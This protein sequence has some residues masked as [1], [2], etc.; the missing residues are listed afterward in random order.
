M[1]SIAAL[2]LGDAVNAAERNADQTTG[3][4]SSRILV[5]CTY[6]KARHRH[7]QL[8]LARDPAIVRWMS[9]R[10]LDV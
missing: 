10:R 1:A 6:R 3:V 7:Q 2:S 8:F 5:A 4:P 9:E